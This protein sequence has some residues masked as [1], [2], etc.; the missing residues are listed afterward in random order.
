MAV[1]AYDLGYLLSL[2]SGQSVLRRLLGDAPKE[3]GCARAAHFNFCGNDFSVAVRSFGEMS[4]AFLGS[5]D[6]TTRTRLFTCPPTP[7]IPT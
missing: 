6:T 3:G 2:F 5:L 7:R 1:L 4:N